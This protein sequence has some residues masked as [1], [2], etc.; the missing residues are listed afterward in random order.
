[1]DGVQ[2]VGALTIGSFFTQSKPENL[3]LLSSFSRELGLEI[4][5]LRGGLFSWCREGGSY[6]ALRVSQPFERI[7]SQY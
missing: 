5:E 1:M 4:D 7:R 3:L 6:N 2:P